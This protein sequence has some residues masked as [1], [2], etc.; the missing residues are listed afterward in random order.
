MP[1]V[2]YERDIMSEKLL[3]RKKALLMTLVLGICFLFPLTSYASLPGAIPIPVKINIS[4]T[5]EQDLP[6]EWTFQFKLT[7]KDGEKITAGAPDHLNS[8]SFDKIVW[9]GGSSISQNLTIDIN[10][11]NG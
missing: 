3:F 9:N 2:Y 5:G 8:L 4:K 7:E 1:K 11:V 6:A 10:Q